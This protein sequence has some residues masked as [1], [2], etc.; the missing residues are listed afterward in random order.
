MS[1]HDQSLAEAIAAAAR[2]AFS[3]WRQAHQDERLFA[4]ALSTIDDAL[5]VNASV[6]TEESHRRTLARSRIQLDAPEALYY[7]WGPYDWEYEYI[8]PSHFKSLDERIKV[9]YDKMHKTEFET[10]RQRVLEAMVQA[11]ILLRTENAIPGT[12]NASPVVLFATIYDSSD[13]KELQHRSAQAANPVD[14]L[15][16]FLSSFRE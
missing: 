2:S 4:F 9:M 11:L 16:E 3:E 10:F 8:A 5:Y 1:D 15:A 12:P 14:C 13:A 7:K 6:N